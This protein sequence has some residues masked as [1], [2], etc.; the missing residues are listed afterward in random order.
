MVIK[1]CDAGEHT[2]D[3]SQHNFCP[4]CT[5]D[6]PNESNAS[7]LK[8]G[9]TIKSY[10]VEGVIN[11]SN[12]AITYKCRD[13]KTNE[14]TILKEIFPKLLSYRSNHSDKLYAKKEYGHD[15]SNYINKVKNRISTIILQKHKNIIEINGIIEINNTIYLI[16]PYI[17][18]E[19]LDSKI[20]KHL[21]INEEYVIKFIVLPLLNALAYLHS[22]N[23]L[24]LDIKT[25]NIIMESGSD[26]VILLD[27]D[28]TIFKESI[29]KKA[30]F[31]IASDGFSPIEQLSSNF[32]GIGV[33][34]D[35]YSLG[36]VFYNCLFSKN[37]VP[38]ATA[39]SES[40]INY[41]KDCLTPASIRGKDNYS[42]EFL[43][44]I[45]WMLRLNTTE[46]PQSALECI[47]HI[48]ENKPAPFDSREIKFQANENNQLS[49]EQAL[50]PEKNRL[51]ISPPYSFSP[52]PLIP[53]PPIKTRFV[54]R[55]TNNKGTQ[56]IFSSNK[57]DR[58][59]KKNLIQENIFLYI[60]LVIG[61][62]ILSSALLGLFID[63]PFSI[64]DISFYTLGA[65]L[66][67][68]IA[69]RSA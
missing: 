54:E 1:R 50:L 23:E 33:W 61:G 5:E 68:L 8:I 10:I 28:T 19:L 59:K 52:P 16:M 62:V 2:Y 9:S 14:I 51:G 26:R 27:L 29:G 53:P 41:G 31:I 21:I 64:R 20:T 30:S 32:N 42:F 24:H 36:C 22:L 12:M 43:S 13:E 15:Y 66:G 55:I 69:R 34:S 49:Q 44:I 56:L 35:I 4:F 40:I 45:D 37:L 25:N 57:I 38:S 47:N 65:L 46:R 48:Q 63:D 58:I 67:Y 60:S 39:R 7:A 3:G 18:G 11:D 6:V 17:K